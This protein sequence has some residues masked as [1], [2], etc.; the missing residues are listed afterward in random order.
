MSDYG[1]HLENIFPLETS[2]KHQLV[3]TQCPR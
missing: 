3:Y 2:T 1:W